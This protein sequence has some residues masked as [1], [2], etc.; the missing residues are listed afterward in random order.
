MMLDMTKNFGNEISG[1]STDELS[2][3]ELLTSSTENVVNQHTGLPENFEL[4]NQLP[5]IS[6]EILE[7]ILKLE[8][9]AKNKNTNEQT[10]YYTKNFKDFLSTERLPTCIETIPKQHL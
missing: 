6:K 10:K 9:E 4:P 8:D 3:L 1:I 5:E 7:E 2:F